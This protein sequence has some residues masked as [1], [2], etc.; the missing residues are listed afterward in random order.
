MA[1]LIT[2]QAD[3]ITY[4]CYSERGI[5]SYFM[6]RVVPREITTFL[7]HQIQFPKDAAHPFSSLQENEIGKVAI[8][9]ELDL[10]EFGNPDGALFFS[11]NTNN[12]LIFEEGKFNEK[13]E[14][15]CKVRKRKSRATENVAHIAHELADQKVESK[16]ID[17]TVSSLHELKD[18]PSTIQG[19][20]ELRYRLIRLYKHYPAALFID[21]KTKNKCVKEIPEVK[22]YYLSSDHFYQQ[23]LTKDEKELGA[24]RHLWLTEG[25]KKLFTKYVDQCK[26]ENILF[27]ISTDDTS[28]PFDSIKPDLRPQLFDASWEESKHR[29]GWRQKKVIEQCSHH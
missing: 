18:R 27:V 6:F 3:G 22:R 23:R 13:Y 24:W 12:Y 16:S 19:Q 7:K 17:K 26:E 10:G 29:F 21:G 14:D 9:S 2:K 28:N 5:L 1:E 4:E 8:F 25:V 20:L 11:V 15:S